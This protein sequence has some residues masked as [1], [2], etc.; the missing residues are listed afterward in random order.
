MQQKYVGGTINIEQNAVI[1]MV[2]L[3][4]FVHFLFGN[5]K[6]VGPLRASFSLDIKVYM[7]K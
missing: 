3:D 1:V 5:I 2:D 7:C 4:L 6:F